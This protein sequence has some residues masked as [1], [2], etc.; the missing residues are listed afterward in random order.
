MSAPGNRWAY[1][2]AVPAQAMRMGEW[3]AVRNK[4]GAPLE[5]YNLAEDISEST[6]LAP[7]KPEALARIQKLLAAAHSEPRPPL[8]FKDAWRK[9]SAA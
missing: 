5:L 9:S 3:K 7:K 6:D 8:P 2:T 1:S 4:A